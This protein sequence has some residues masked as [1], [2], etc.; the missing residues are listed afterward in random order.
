MLLVAACAQG[1]LTASPSTVLSA[2]I[3]AGEAIGSRGG[4]S[5]RSPTARIP[6]SPPA[7]ATTARVLSTADKY[8]GTPYTWGG[9]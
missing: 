3:L 1:T 4:S 6:R 9:N 2:V 8:V 5:T 7:T